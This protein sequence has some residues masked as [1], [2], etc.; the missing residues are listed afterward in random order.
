MIEGCLEWQQQGL[1]PPDVISY[2]TAAYLDAEDN[3]FAWL[4]ESCVRDPN[5]WERTV[6]LFASWSRWAREQGE[7]CGNLKQFKG[8]LVSRG[9]AHKRDAAL[10]GLA[11]KAYVSN[12]VK[13]REGMNYYRRYARV[14]S[15]ISK[16][17][18]CLHS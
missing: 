4:E 1:S 13:G 15:I 18:T 9:F 3:F 16:P 12:G 7:E 10:E 17:F 11:I 2:A 14:T 8:H 5:G 6:D